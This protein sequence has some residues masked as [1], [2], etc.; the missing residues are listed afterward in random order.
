MNAREIADMV[1][2]DH[3]KFVNR[4]YFGKE[5]LDIAT[6][7]TDTMLYGIAYDMILRGDY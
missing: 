2:Y 1:L 6:I 5:F 3:E 4:V 7:I